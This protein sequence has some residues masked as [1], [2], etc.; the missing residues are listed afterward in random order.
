[1]ATV[2]KIALH[3]NPHLDEA[4]AV[5]VLGKFGEEQFPGISKATLI[6]WG[7]GKTPDNMTAQEWLEKEGV[8]A[9]GIG[10]GMFDEHGFGS[11]DCAAT[12]IA[13]HLGIQNDEALKSLLEYVRR[14]DKGELISSPFHLGA[15]FRMIQAGQGDKNAL[16]WA[17]SAFD[18][19]HKDQIRFLEARAEFAK[20]AKIRVIDGPNGQKFILAI[21][22]SENTKMPRLAR[23]PHGAKADI[24]VVKNPGTGQ[25]LV[26]LSKRTMASLREVVRVIRLLELK[27]RGKLVISNWEDTW[28]RLEGG[29][30]PKLETWFYHQQ[31]EM[32]MNGSLSAPEVPPTQLKISQIVWAIEVCLND[33]TWHKYCLCPEAETCASDHQNP[34]RIWWLGLD[35]C[36][37]RRGE[38]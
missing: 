13:K 1:M 32:L 17:F 33:Q 8:L 23:S 29:R 6:Y 36:R 35:R 15:I 34:C 28:R 12:L 20:K 19:A 21:V 9:I 27:K 3:A 11:D 2:R 16:L 24:V 31:M 4:L 22:E 30:T 26:T 5:W 18:A 25:V 10:G 14:H 37:Q 7:Q 38:T